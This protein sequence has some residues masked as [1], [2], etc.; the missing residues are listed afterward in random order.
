MDTQIWPNRPEPDGVS[1]AA[2]PPS[3]RVIVGA[4][5][6]AFVIMGLTASAA[7][8]TE[9]V[10]EEIWLATAEIEYRGDSLVE[11]IAVALNSPGVWG[12]I[13]IDNDITIKDFQ[14]HYRAEVVG[15]TQALRVEFEDPDPEKAKRIVQ[16]V[17]D[18]YIEQFTVVDN[19][20]QIGTLERYLESL[21][22]VE[23][24]LILVLE[25]TAELTRNE[26]IDRQNELIAVRQAIT[27]V[28][29]RLD[30][31]ASELDDLEA[32]QPRVI[33]EPYVLPEPI[34]PEPLKMA[35]VGAGAGGVLAVAAAFF[36]FHRDE[37][38]KTDRRRDDDWEL[39]A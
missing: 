2:E 38:S 29:L 27:Q 9:Y 26:Q 4:L 5:A 21:R 22:L 17:I 11:T 36:L 15:G 18:S 14:E 34:E 23:T 31:R 10:G 13:A 24:D 39:A 1:V 16:Q 33:S 8:A 6:A 30:G 25:D 37:M 35:V 28:L 19:S 32:I 3:W 20:V 7:F 12:P